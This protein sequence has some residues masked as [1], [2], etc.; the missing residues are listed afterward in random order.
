MSKAQAEMGNA[1]I[2]HFDSI[3]AILDEEFKL[4]EE[5]QS[6]VDLREDHRN[7]KE[8][9]KSDIIRDKLFSLGWKL[10]DTPFG[11]KVTKV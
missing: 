2:N 10:K 1:F 6:L 7:N 3:F 5:I 9:E 8:W 11:T 4:P